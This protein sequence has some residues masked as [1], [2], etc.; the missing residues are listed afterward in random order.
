LKVCKTKMFHKWMKVNKIAGTKLKETTMEISAGLIDVHLGGGLYKKR[1]QTTNK[2]KSEGARV[3][4]AY[5]KEARLIF[6]YG[7]NK[8]EK[9]NIS[10]KEQEAFKKLADFYLNL[11]DFAITKALLIHELMEVKL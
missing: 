1:I 9:D 10:K 3:I 5:K 8:N 7:F 6:L 4:L 2:G 11:T